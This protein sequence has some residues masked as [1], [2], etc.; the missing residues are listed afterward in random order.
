MS[1]KIDP[2]LGYRAIGLGM[3]PQFFLAILSHDK[4]LK[5]ADCQLG[6]TLQL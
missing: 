1:Q 3:E 2:Q 5:V 4:R 6:S